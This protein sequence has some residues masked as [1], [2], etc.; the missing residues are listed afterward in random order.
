MPNHI[1]IVR[2]RD[3]EELQKLSVVGNLLWFSMRRKRVRE[4]QN[5]LAQF[6][7]LRNRRSPQNCILDTPVVV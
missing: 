5:A 2:A 1:C 7:T 3:M 6:G 4:I